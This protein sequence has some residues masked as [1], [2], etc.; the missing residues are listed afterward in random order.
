MTRKFLKIALIT[1]LIVL[2]VR[3]TLDYFPDQPF[4]HFRE[5]LDFPGFL[6]QGFVIALLS[7]DANDPSS[8]IHGLDRIVNFIVL[9]V[10]TF[11][12]LLCLVCVSIPENR[13]ANPKRS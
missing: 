4:W 5:L 2:P 1:L 10:V 3:M 12:V 11:L 7:T 6:F 9:Y 13:R 8:Y